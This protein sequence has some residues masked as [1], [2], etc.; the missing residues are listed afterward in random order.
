MQILKRNN[1]RPHKNEANSVHTRHPSQHLGILHKEMVGPLKNIISDNIQIK[2]G[3][4]QIPQCKKWQYLC[5][6]LKT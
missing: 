6:S 4:E 2:L 5:A 1:T 3:Y